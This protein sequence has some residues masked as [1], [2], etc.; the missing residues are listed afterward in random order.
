L[1]KEASLYFRKLIY[2]VYASHTPLTE[3]QI[4]ESLL[5][6]NFETN[7][8][9]DVDEKTLNDR[10]KQF[11]NIRHAEH[12]ADGPIIEEATEDDSNRYVAK[13]PF[14]ELK[15]EKP[16]HEKSITAL[17][18]LLPEITSATQSNEIREGDRISSPE[19]VEAVRNCINQFRS[20]TPNVWDLVKTKSEEFH[21]TGKLHLSLKDTHMIMLEKDAEE[22]I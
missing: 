2:K 3:S 14:K 16:N 15:Y 18:S 6:F 22:L 8:P 1:S 17:I 19:S 5:S 7:K 13:G 9:F 20:F 4:I 11:Q 21:R 10:I 12:K